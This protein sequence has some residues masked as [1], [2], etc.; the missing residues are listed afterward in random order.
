MNK[1]WPIAPRCGHQPS[2]ASLLLAAWAD[3]QAAPAAS[4]GN[5]DVKQKSPQLGY[6]RSP[7]AAVSG[8]GGGTMPS[9]R[10]LSTEAWWQLWSLVFLL[11]SASLLRTC[12]TA[13]T[14]SQGSLPHA[15]E[16]RRHPHACCMPCGHT[17]K[18][19]WWWE[20][21]GRW[22]RRASS[23]YRWKDSR[24]RLQWLSH[25][26]WGFGNDPGSL[27]GLDISGHFWGPGSGSALL[28]GA[29]AYIRSPKV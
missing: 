14:P 16:G 6:T 22:R 21:M 5:L 7:A 10:G 11:E 27:I 17:E 26:Q 18:Q 9:T 28:A 20:R 29:H 24:V 25:C 15:C 23:F 12:G 4:Q 13:Q 8:E 2:S 19:G 1:H 3:E